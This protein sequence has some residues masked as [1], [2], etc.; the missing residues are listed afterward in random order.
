M[1]F[2]LSLNPIRSL[3]SKH[4]LF[5]YRVDCLTLQRRRSGLRQVTKPSKMPIRK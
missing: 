3:E 1:L 2:L 4:I 5:Y